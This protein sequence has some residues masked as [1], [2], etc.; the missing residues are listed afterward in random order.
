MF[1]SILNL[2]TAGGDARQQALEYLQEEPEVRQH[3]AKLAHREE[4]ARSIQESHP[5]G[6]DRVAMLQA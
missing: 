4:W 2:G 6:P 1:L 3:A 5:Q